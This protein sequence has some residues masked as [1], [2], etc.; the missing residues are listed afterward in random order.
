MHS[1]EVSISIETIESLMN[2]FNTIAIGTTAT[3]A[4]ESLYWI[5]QELFNNDIELNH[6]DQWL[7]Y[8]KHKSY[9]NRMD[10]LKCIHKYLTTKQKKSIQF[11]TS[12]LIVPGYKFR[13]V[14]LLLT[15]FHQPKSTLLLL[16]AAAV[17]NEWKAI[18]DYA[19]QMNFRFLSYG[20][21]CLLKVK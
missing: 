1:E 11:S 17:G 20:D 6:V 3:R 13:F 10:S 8:K 12:L 21:A 7:P 16:I 15:N 2:K 4:L 19:L 14:D 5:S 18:Y 9:L